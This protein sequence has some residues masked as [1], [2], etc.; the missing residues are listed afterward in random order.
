MKDRDWAIEKSAAWID[1]LADMYTD[2][3]AINR[4]LPAVNGGGQVD[5]T[6]TAVIALRKEVLTLL[7][8]LR[9]LATAPIFD[10]EP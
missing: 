9:G 2:L 4:T 1:Q 10:H 3:S 6:Q 5:A 7:V 8:E